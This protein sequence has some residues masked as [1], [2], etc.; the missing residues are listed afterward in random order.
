MHLFERIETLMVQQTRRDTSITRR[1]IGSSAPE[2]L[3]GRVQRRASHCGADA[4]KSLH[5]PMT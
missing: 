4:G 1:K 3:R 5:G 2:G